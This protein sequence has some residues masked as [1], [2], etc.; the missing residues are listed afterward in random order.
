LID[1]LLEQRAYPHPVSGPELL[2]THISWVILTGEFAYK[3]KK[4]VRLDFLDFSTLEQRKH[5]C[6]EELRLNRAW[7]PA[8]YLEVVPICGS[9]AAPRVGGEGTPFEYALKMRQFP[10]SARLDH[11]L[12]AGLLQPRDMPPLAETVARIHEQAAVSRCPTP[13]DALRRASAPMPDNFPPMEPYADPAALG[14]VRDWTRRQLATCEETLAERDHSGFVRECHGD[15]HLANLVRWNSEIVAFD[16]VEFSPDLRTIDVISDIAFL[17]MDLI[18]RGRRDL[19]YVFLNRYLERSGDYDGMSLYGLYFVY[20]CMIRAKVAAIR[21]GERALDDT[22]G[23][24]VD[25][26]EVRH[27]MNVALRWIDRKAPFIAAMHGYSGSGKSWLSARLAAR[28]PAIRV[29]SDVERKRQFELPETARSGS[30]V[31]EGIYTQDAKRSVY[32][33]LFE[34]AEHLLGAKLNVV[35]DASF[36]ESEHRAGLAQLADRLQVP[37]LW[38]ET[39]ADEADIEQRLRGRGGRE[40]SEAGLDVLRAQLACP[41]PLR[42]AERS[43]CVSVDTTGPVEW[44]E[45]RAD[46]LRAVSQPPHRES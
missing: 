28:L 14:R 7:A 11:Q 17:A 23:R 25:L 37:F 40:A 3:I 41:D 33:R 8:L 42:P 1:A 27:Y 30:A 6:E 10:Q 22:A 43:A 44:A 38:I 5:F 18:G 35:L 26:D 13:G 4:P 12:E 32:D 36:L 31:G 16:C 9:P 39:R 29:R 45:L 2:E 24:G 34:I 46:I 20:H 19:A 21:A 15:L